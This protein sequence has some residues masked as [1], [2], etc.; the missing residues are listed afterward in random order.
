MATYAITARHVPTQPFYKDGVE[1]L[2]N[3]RRTYRVSNMYHNSESLVVCVENPMQ[4]I[5]WTIYHKDGKTYCKSR[6]AAFWRVCDIKQLTTEPPSL[7]SLLVPC[8]FS[9]KKRYVGR[10]KVA[11]KGVTAHLFGLN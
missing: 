7:P 11:I 9:K 4:Q 3:P 10:V 5:G 2:P 8:S 6:D 1:V